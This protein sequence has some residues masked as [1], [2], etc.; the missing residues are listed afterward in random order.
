[1][2]TEQRRLGPGASAELLMEIFCVFREPIER[3]TTLTMVRII[4]AN[5]LDV[6]RSRKH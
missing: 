5:M 2:T 1:L 3:V 6:M 4:C